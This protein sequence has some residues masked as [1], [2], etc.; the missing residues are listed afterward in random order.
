MARVQTSK[1][2]AILEE[3][4]ER[5]KAIRTENPRYKRGLRRW[6]QFLEDRTGFR[7]GFTTARRYEEG[8]FPLTA[9]YLLAVCL[10]TDTNPAWVLSGQGPQKWSHIEQPNT[11]EVLERLLSQARGDALTV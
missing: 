2:E 3:V 1:I 7:V 5:L 11:V 4:R 8:E 9:E 6:V 10:A